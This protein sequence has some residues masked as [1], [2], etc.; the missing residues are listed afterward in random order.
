M[1]ADNIAFN[2]EQ[3]NWNPARCDAYFQGFHVLSS[4]IYAHNHDLL[5]LQHGRF[6]MGHQEPHGVQHQVPTQEK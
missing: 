4:H 5:F 3:Q 2:R 1:V 6:V